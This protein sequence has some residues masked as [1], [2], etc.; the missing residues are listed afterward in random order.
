M[1]GIKAVIDS[2]NIEVCFYSEN[3][4][5]IIKYPQGITY[6]NKSYAVIKKA[7]I[8]HLGIKKYPDILSVSGRNLRVN[9]SLTDGKIQFLNANGKVLLSEKAGGAQFTRC[10]DRPDPVYKIKQSFRLT[11]NEVIYGLG[12]HQSGEMNK[13]GRHI[14]LQQ[15]NMQIAIPYFYSTKGYGLFW[16]NTSTTL[17]DDTATE[18]SFKSEAG[19]GMDYYFLYGQSMEEGLH[20]WRGLTGHAPLLPR[21]AYGYWQSKERYTSREE[22]LEVVKRYRS[23][24]IPLDVIVQDWQYWGMDN[25]EWNSTE[26]GNP[27]Y[28]K[29]KEM[30]DRL[31][32]MDAHIAISVWPDFGKNTAIY[33]DMERHGFLYRMISFPPSK[34]IKVYDAFNP[35]ARDIYWNY[36]NRNLFSIGMDAWWLDATEPEQTY[37]DENNNIKTYD[38][39]FGKV[40]NAYPIATVRGVYDHQR[41]QTTEKRVTI[42]TRSA[43]AGQQRYGSIIWSGDVQASWESLKVQIANGLNMSVCGIPYWNSDI[44]GFF[45]YA[46]YP[47]GVSDPAYQELYVRWLEF[48]A[49]CPIM[50]SHGANTPREIY[51]FGHKGDWSYDAIARFIKLRYRLLPYIYSVAWQVTSRSGTYMRPLVMDFPQDKNTRKQ[52]SEYLFGPLFLV[53]P[54]TVPFYTSEVNGRAKISFKKVR[55]WQVY[56]PKG[57]DWFN[58][59]TGEKISGGK[60][61]N[62][63][64]PIDEIPLFVRSGSILPLG[65]VVQWATQKPEAVL[66]IRIYPGADGDFVLYED[67]ND[68]YDYEKGGY[69]TISFTWKNKNN[70]LT[71]AKRRGNFRG[72]L[73]KRT[74]HL[75][76]IGKNR[77]NGADTAKDGFRIVKYNGEKMEVAF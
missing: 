58:F 62:C 71:I 53:A 70:I 15:Q 29:P 27:R 54:V 4:V 47:R 69:S 51:R 23:L 48:S 56:L 65:P 39:L 34:D 20:E 76:I 16:D 14:L 8:V 60:K 41:K 3:I 43:F 74:F 36:L 38:G 66:E 72:I 77:C 49:F 10:D 75:V 55:N 63:K 22:L 30:M 68:G 11:A 57:S 25:D 64:A 59:W 6:K 19:D 13:R 28:P 9:I 5:R 24:H 45:S 32:A 67:G 31:H 50:R 40:R 46:H 35:E 37:P 21:W 61:F 2:L 52:S 42:L 26:F 18:T 33:K 17:F 1:N 7:Q 44:G 12:Q 73:Q